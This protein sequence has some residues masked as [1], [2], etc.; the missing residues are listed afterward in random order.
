MVTT[1]GSVVSGDLV[2]VGFTVGV[3]LSEVREE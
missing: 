2:V 1:V 3:R